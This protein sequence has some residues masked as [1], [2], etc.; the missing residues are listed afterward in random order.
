MHGDVQGRREAVEF[1]GADLLDLE[2]TRGYHDDKHDVEDG[3]SQ[4][5]F[6]RHRE[7]DHA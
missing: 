4:L 6:P 2:N 3:V 1:V 7:S 5:H